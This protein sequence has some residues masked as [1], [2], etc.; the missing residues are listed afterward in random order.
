MMLYKKNITNGKRDRGSKSIKINIDEL[1][2][3]PKY[4]FKTPKDRKKFI[5]T[6]EA[7]IRKSIEY[8]DYIK[9][10]KQNMDMSKCIILRSLEV[11]NGKKYTI[12]IHHEP[13]TLFD[14]VDTVLIKREEN[15]ETINPLLIADEVMEL[16]YAGK[17]GLVPLTT[18]MHELVHNDRIFIP[19]QFIYHKYNEFYEEY[20]PYFRQM[21]LDK[22][23][24]KVNLSL[25][26]DDVISDALDV[27]FSYIQIDGFNFPTVPDEWKDVI[28]ISNQS[29]SSEDSDAQ[30]S[31]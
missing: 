12:E 29:T 11:G 23:E 17:V 5:A 6:C 27:E 1:P 26:C 28:G 24:A 19:L 9:F 31:E 2:E 20:Q 16:H 15:G 21:L 3:R 14:I 25:K 7:T 10:L 4:S 18:T 30:S 22:I 8:K 13:F